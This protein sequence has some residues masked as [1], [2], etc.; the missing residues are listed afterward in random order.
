M[1]ESIIPV[2]LADLFTT[3]I[4]GTGVSLIINLGNGLFGGTTPLIVT[5]IA[6]L[7]QN[8]L[9]PALYLIIIG[10]VTL[11][12]LLCNLTLLGKKSPTSEPN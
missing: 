5:S 10:L 12:F 11:F 1:Y 2:I 3:E 9:A 6:H 7:M 8:N 4:R